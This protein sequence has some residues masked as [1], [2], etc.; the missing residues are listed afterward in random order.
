MAAFGLIINSTIQRQNKLAERGSA[1]VKQWADQFAELS[2]EIDEKATS[3][4]ANYFKI[5]H[6]DSF[7]AENADEEIR[8]FEQFIRDTAFFLA[9]E[10]LK[11]EK[12]AAIAP[13][14]GGAVLAAFDEL[15]KE[16]LQWF[17][18]KGGDVDAFREK[19]ARF[20]ELSRRIHREILELD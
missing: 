4:L 18:N 6:K 17:A 3:I 16:A 9:I 2:I 20:N 5:K 13:R 1:F 10:K 7:I 8:R 19:Q 14:N 11:L 12:F 15:H